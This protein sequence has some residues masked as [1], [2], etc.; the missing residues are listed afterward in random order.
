MDDG[1]TYLSRVTHS[2][3]LSEHEEGTGV[4]RLSEHPFRGDLPIGSVADVAFRE[5]WMRSGAQSFEAARTL[6][7][8]RSH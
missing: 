7:R 6:D 2:G 8:P 1:A 5:I 4:L 3:E